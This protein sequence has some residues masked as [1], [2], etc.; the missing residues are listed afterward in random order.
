MLRAHLIFPIL[1]GLSACVGV[2]NEKNGFQSNQLEISITERIRNDLK[3]DTN[4]VAGKTFHTGDGL[5]GYVINFEDD[6]TY[7]TFGF[8]DI[9][10]GGGSI[11][12]YV[13]KSKTIFMLDSICFE[14]KPHFT[15]PK[16]FAKCEGSTMT[17]YFLVKKGN[18][19][20]LSSNPKDTINPNEMKIDFSLPSFDLHEAEIPD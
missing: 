5:G 16:V 17:H 11:G 9:C 8:C 14:N 6:R 13:Q 10:P 3:I 4:S 19:L 12:T 2:D 7:R 15:S 1:I 18:T 20:Y